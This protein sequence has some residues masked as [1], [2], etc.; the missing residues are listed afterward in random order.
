MIKKLEIDG[1][2]SVVNDRLRKYVA[3]KIGKLDKYIPRH[4]RLSAH[5]EVKLKETKAKD[6]NQCTCEV[7]LHLPNETLNVRETTIN[8]LAAID[9]VEAKL[10]NQLKK[11]KET[12]SI[13]IHRRVIARV[14]Q[15]L[16][17][18]K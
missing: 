10:K 8:M 12:H 3:K 1:V 5:A 13:K 4:A 14:K 9:I 16:R 18:K 15:G 6:K 7:I 2:H 17:P 11:Y